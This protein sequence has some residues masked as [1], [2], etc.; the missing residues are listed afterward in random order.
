MQAPLVNAVTFAPPQ[1][2]GPAFM[3]RYSKLVN[4]RGVTFTDD[5]VQQARHRVGGLLS[6]A[7]CWAR[8][9]VGWGTLS[10]DGTAWQARLWARWAV[11]RQC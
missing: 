1:V 3:D 6:V 4:S 11:L 2:G 7:D 5:I 8:Q 10:G 9:P